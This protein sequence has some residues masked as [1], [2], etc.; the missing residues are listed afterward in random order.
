MQFFITILFSLCTY[1][2]VAQEAIPASLEKID[3]LYEDGKT[4]YL[5]EAYEE[6]IRSWNEELSLKKVQYGNKHLE[7]AR[8]LYN[9]G[10]A[11]FDWD[12]L[13]EAKS[14]FQQSL[15]IRLDQ[16][17]IKSDEKLRKFTFANY[18]QL[19]KIEVD[20]G[21]FDNAL[22]LFKD[23]TRELKPQQN[24]I[25]D[26]LKYKAQALQDAG[27]ES[28]AAA[29]KIYEEIIETFR[30]QNEIESAGITYYDLGN[31]LN[32]NNEFS[33]AHTAYLHAYT[34]LYEEV[35]ELSIHIIN[36]AN[37]LGASHIKMGNLE[38]A[39]KLLKETIELTEA[40]FEDEK[41]P[42]D[43][44]FPYDNLG[45]LER[46][47][48]N[49]PAAKAHYEKALS[50]LIHNF[51]PDN[52]V[53]LDANEIKFKGPK[54]ETLTVLGSL[55]KTLSLLNKK[56]QA[57]N[58]YQLID[59]VLFNLRQDLTTES[60]NLHWIQETRDF[61]ENA[62]WIAADLN[63]PKK[64]FNFIEKSKAVLLFENLVKSERQNLKNLPEEV[65]K[66]R[67]TL[68]R[69]IQ[70][71][72]ENN[73]SGTTL[74]N[75]KKELAT[76][77]NEN[78]LSGL[79][80]LQIKEKSLDRFQEYLRT[81][82]ST[83][84]EFF[85]SGE[86][87]MAAVINDKIKIFKF[88]N[89]ND[90]DILIDDWIKIIS[91][92]SNQPEDFKQIAQ[93]GNKLYRK[94]IEPLSLDKIENLIIIPDGKLQFFPFEALLTESVDEEERDFSNL[95]YLFKKY[96]IQYAY[97]ANVQLQ[98]SAI[99]KSESNNTLIIS[100]ESFPW[101]SALND[102]TG[103][104][105][106]QIKTITKGH[107]LSKEAATVSSFLQIYQDY[108]LVH[109][110]THAS[111]GIRSPWIAF[112]DR[113]L[114]LSELS[115][116]Q[117]NIKLLILSACETAKGE[118]IKGEG[119]MSLSRGF[120]FTGIPQV[121]TTLWEVNEGSTTKIME[122]FHKNLKTGIPASKALHQAKTQYIEDNALSAAHPYYWAALTSIGHD[123]YR[124]SSNSGKGRYLVL[125][126]FVVSALFLLKKVL[127]GERK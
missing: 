80:L 100:P 82:K 59:Q 47:K 4:A 51:N 69:N 79:D 110:S 77:D 106:E 36:A 55:A 83:A 71:F 118:L 74:E 126:L 30:S 9:L 96:P 95:P 48:K 5:N 19:I 54:I 46:S 17:K 62:A 43:L 93:I 94:L 109:F 65:Q 72:E 98:L 86:Q 34:I 10:A 2:L 6:A 32:S 24:E 14:Y 7:V 15:A 26:I 20:L 3:S 114:S 120:S 107:L 53:D 90:R 21:D 104:E 91:I 11:H 8:T 66:N 60:S 49:Y 23:C 111:S 63:H 125:L 22:S 16:L 13:I 119:V 99:E 33:K 88:P 64:A 38:D 40:Y 35:G 87:L 76:F 1:L 31:A 52:F 92:K 42:Y 97:S 44:A 123:N 124:K 112:K 127:L 25:P 58:A 105:A 73:E 45:D 67:A 89:D 108:D 37:N 85:G 78:L 61:Y 75:L 56:E 81:S 117:S 12:Y 70:N 50:Y 27:G 84:I 68:V 18:K 39:D 29:I 115:S 101:S 103:E 28:T 57:L 102:L 41:D 113:K 121:I 116:F 122:A